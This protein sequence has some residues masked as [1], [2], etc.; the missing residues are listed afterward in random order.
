MLIQHTMSALDQLMTAA[1][2]EAGSTVATQ[3]SHDASTKVEMRCAELQKRRAKALKD[4]KG[5]AGWWKFL[6][7]VCTRDNDTDVMTA[8]N[9]LCTLCDTTLSASNEK[10]HCS[11]GFSCIYL[12]HLKAASRT[13]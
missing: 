1:S 11:L 7:V 10:L 6:Q 3:S 12:Q 8:V 2:S 4:A 13:V 5:T 9:L